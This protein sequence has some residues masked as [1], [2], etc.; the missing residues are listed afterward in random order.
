ML[1]LNSNDNN[2]PTTRSS[3]CMNTYEG[4]L[5]E[6]FIVNSITIFLCRMVGNILSILLCRYG[7]E[8][9][10]CRGGSSRHGGHNPISTTSTNTTSPSGENDQGDAA[11]VSSHN[12]LASDNHGK[13]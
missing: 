11:S 13:R 9:C 12:L 4:K 3:S 6:K 7:S 2:G 8:D 10:G 1:P 5:F